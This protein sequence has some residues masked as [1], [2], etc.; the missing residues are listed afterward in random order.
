MFIVFY[1]QSRRSSASSS[2]KSGSLSMSNTSTPSHTPGMSAPS[3]QFYS[4]KVAQISQK[5]PL[6]TKVY[7][8]LPVMGM[9]GGYKLRPG[10]ES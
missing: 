9:C 5:L 7:K 1:F 8:W 4:K 3:H 6:F 10:F 2:P